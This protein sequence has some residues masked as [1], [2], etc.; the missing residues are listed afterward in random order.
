MY[1]CT[2]LRAGDCTCRDVILIT[3]RRW[4]DL[5]DILTGTKLRYFDLCSPSLLILLRVLYNRRWHFSTSTHLPAYYIVLPLWPGKLAMSWCGAVRCENCFD[6]LLSKSRS[7]LS[8]FIWIIPTRCRSRSSFLIPSS[9]PNDTETSALLVPSHLRPSLIL[10]YEVFPFSAHDH[11]LILCA[12][13]LR[14]MHFYC[15]VRACTANHPL[16]ILFVESTIPF[17]PA[18]FF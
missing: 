10:S 14:I 7:R 12:R 15:P 5:L 16:S 17:L 8:N 13:H 4:L 3:V 1:V 11:G 18:L 9:S 2:W 6:L